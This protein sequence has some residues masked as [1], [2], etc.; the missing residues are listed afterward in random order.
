MGCTICT[1]P[2]HKVLHKM[3]K[4]FPSLCMGEATLPLLT[5]CKHLCTYQEEEDLQLSSEVDS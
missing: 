4:A 5:L 1:V 3:K 2:L